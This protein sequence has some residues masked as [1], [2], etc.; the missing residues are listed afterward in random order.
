MSQ[1]MIDNANIYIPSYMLLLKQVTFKQ[2]SKLAM[3]KILGLN[4]LL[5]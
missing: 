4:K 5:Q 1:E 2:I 3:I